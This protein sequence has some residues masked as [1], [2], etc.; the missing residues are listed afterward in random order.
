MPKRYEP[1]AYVDLGALSSEL[2]EDGDS[3]A[4][5]APDAEHSCSGKILLLLTSK[6]MEVVR[7]PTR[8]H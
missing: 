4:A 2:A 7:V 3:A 6:G 1:Y 5:D 8:L